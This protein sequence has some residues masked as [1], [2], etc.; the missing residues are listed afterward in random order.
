MKT[1][2]NVQYL[3]HIKGRLKDLIDYDW[4][5]M[6]SSLKEVSG[7]LN[8]YAQEQAMERALRKQRIE[9]RYSKF[10]KNANYREQE[11]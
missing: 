7:L 10:E 2:D 11:R 6:V 4:L 3:W 9:Q 8:E 1:E 5:C